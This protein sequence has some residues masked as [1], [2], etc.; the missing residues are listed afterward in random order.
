MEMRREKTC[1][2][3]FPPHD[4]ELKLLRFN[5]LIICAEGYGGSSLR[6]VTP[7]AWKRCVITI[8]GITGSEISVTFLL[9]RNESK[10]NC[11]KMFLIASIIIYF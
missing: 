11:R 7:A 8:T 1:V 2:A 4:K 10:I 6:K 3:I 5:I 9:W